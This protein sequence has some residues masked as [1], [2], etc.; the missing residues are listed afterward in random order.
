M[1]TV[2]ARGD[3]ERK[4]SDMTTTAGLSRRTFDGHLETKEESLADTEARSAPRGRRPSPEEG[5]PPGP[6]LPWF[7]FGRGLPSSSGRAPWCR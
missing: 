2:A 7:R 4:A 3:R 1:R 5:E 6:D